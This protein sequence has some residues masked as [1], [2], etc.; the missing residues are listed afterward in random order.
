[1]RE[2]IENIK[3]KYGMS[4]TLTLYMDGSGHI[5]RGIFSD[6]ADYETISFN[7][8]EEFETILRSKAMKGK[9][10]KDMLYCEVYV[11]HGED[12]GDIALHAGD[13]VEIIRDNKEFNEDTYLVLITDS[14]GSE[15][16]TLPMEDIEPIEEEEEEEYTAKVTVCWNA[17]TGEKLY[18]VE[19]FINGVCKYSEFSPSENRAIEYL[20]TFGLEDSI[21]W[22]A[23]KR[24]SENE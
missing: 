15:Y 6:D 13:T 9:V 7:S 3:S 22:N 8:I 23:L 12:P 1:M 20:T 16:A 14:N 24:N 4:A 10:L 17:G 21:N 18:N 2:M 5:T 11:D 19:V